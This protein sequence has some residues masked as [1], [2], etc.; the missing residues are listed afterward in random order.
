MV[1]DAPYLFDMGA[2]FVPHR[3]DVAYFD[4]ELVTLASLRETLVFTRGA[5]GMLARRG[6]FEIGLDDVRRIAAAMGV[7][8]SPRVMKP[9]RACAAAS[10]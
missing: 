4:A 7:T 1:G 5:W 2:G 3:R 6:H 10:G 8:E 9:L